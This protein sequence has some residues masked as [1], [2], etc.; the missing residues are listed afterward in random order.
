MAMAS[1]ATCRLQRI[2][3]GIVEPVDGHRATVHAVWNLPDRRPH[4]VFGTLQDQLADGLQ[5]GQPV[6]VKH[7]DQLASADHVA[8]LLGVQIADHHLRHPHVGADDL[9]Q[10]AV[11]LTAPEQL[12]QRDRQPL[13]EHLAG[14][15][16]HG[17]PADVGGVTGAGEPADAAA[18][19]KHG[20]DHREV[21]QV[22]GRGPGIVGNQGI[23]GTQGGQGMARHHVIDARSWPWC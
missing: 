1:P 8:R 7:L 20:S 9:Q 3:S 16:A 6:L 5:I 4:R 10:L 19:M 23:A 17:Q 12:Q 14:V 15:R 11:G 13:L 21:E 18:A 2:S 22:A